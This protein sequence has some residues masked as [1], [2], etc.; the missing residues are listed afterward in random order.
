MNTSD[1]IF[2]RVIF[3]LTDRRAVFNNQFQLMK[4]IQDMLVSQAEQ[5]GSRALSWSLSGGTGSLRAVWGELKSEE[6]V[7]GSGEG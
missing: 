4:H 7:R 5:A 2:E 6:R 1:P 3:G